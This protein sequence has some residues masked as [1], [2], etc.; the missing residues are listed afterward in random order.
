MTEIEDALF[1]SKA[2]NSVICRGWNYGRILVMEQ[3]SSAYPNI[4][5]WQTHHV[6]CYP[7]AGKLLSAHSIMKTS[8]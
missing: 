3:G 4:R 2:N 6:T 1:A 8:H 7:K 5:I